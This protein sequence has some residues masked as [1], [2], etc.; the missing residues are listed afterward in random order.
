MCFFNRVLLHVTLIITPILILSGCSGNNPVNQIVE[1]IKNE[2]IPIV[3][4]GC[5]CKDKPDDIITVNDFSGCW[6]IKQSTG[7]VGI[8]RFTQSDC[9]ISGTTD[10][11]NHENSKI[12]GTAKGS[13]ITFTLVYP[14]EDTVTYTAMLNEDASSI[15]GG[16]AQSTKGGTFL[17]DAVKGTCVT[18]TVD[19]CW[20]V[21]QNNGHVGVLTFK[22]NGSAI[23]GI[24]GWTTH[25]NGPIE[26]TVDGNK[27]SFTI[28]YPEGVI[29][30][31]E[32][33]ISDDGTALINGITKSSTGDQAQWNANKTVCEVKTPNIQGCWAVDQSNGHIGILTFQQSGTTVTGVSGWTTHSNGPIKGSISGTALS[34]TI[35][36]PEGVIGYYEG[37]INDDGTALINGFGK[38]STGDQAQWNAKKT[39]CEIK[40]PNI[41]GCWAVDQSNGHIGILTFQQSGTTITGT[42]GWTTHSNGPIKGSISGTTLSFSITYPEGVTGYYEGT[43]SEDGTAL[44]N[45]FGKSSTGDQAKWNA[46]KTVCDQQSR[47]HKLSKDQY[48]LALYYFDEIDGVTL[49][50]ETGKASGKITG[51][52]RV[53]GKCGN[54]LQFKPGDYATFDT[55]LPNNLPEGTIELSVKFDSDFDPTKIYSLFGNDGSRIQIIYK[56]GSILFA[57]NHSDDFKFTQSAFTFIPDKWYDIAVMWGSKGMRIFIDGKQVAANTDYTVYQAS[58][59]TSAENIFYIGKKS[60]CCMGGYGISTDLS[61]KGAVDEIRVS[62]VARY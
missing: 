6:N 56:I 29:G 54:A 50:D 14:D 15:T 3:D 12:T 7:D 31:Y 33:T 38:S 61:F 58:P 39:V 48:T 9:E 30:Y 34:F 24:S 8:F 20:A 18:K 23:T 44:I 40:T 36:Y 19:G 53:S 16:K 27:I 55:I 52:T 62:S 21:N 47:C 51:A 13:T 43:I 42:S 60:W 11:A 17:W 22:Q 57:K 49:I 46:K 1:L 59:R 4:K 2:L 28:S 5:N 32:A 45:G 25:S 26:G 35:T 10:W 37:T 41:Q